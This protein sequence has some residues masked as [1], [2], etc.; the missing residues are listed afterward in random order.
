MFTDRLFRSTSPDADPARRLSA[1]SRLPPDSDELAELLAND[2]VP[3][4][5]IAAAEHCSNIDALAAAL[6]AERDHEVR[7]ALAARLGILLSDSDDSTQAVA[8]L[9]ASWC[10]DAIRTDVVRRTSHPERRRAAVMSIADEALLVELALTADIA[11]TRIAATERVHTPEGLRR[12]AEGT[13]D[14]DR[15]VTRLARNRLHA[16][17][18][19]EDRA[20]KADAILAELEAVASAPGPILTRV[21]ELNR[22]WEALDLAHDPERRARCDAVRQ[23]LQRRFEREH[24]QQRARSDL[25]RELA[26]WL[27]R[28]EPPAS[29]DELHTRR[30]ELAAL[31]ERAQQHESATTLGGLDEAEQRL[32]QWARDLEA[33]APAEAMVVEAE[34]LAAATS[35]DDAKLKPRW[36]ALDHSVR[37]PALARRFEAALAVVEQRRR[38]YVHAAQQ[39]ASLARQQVHTLLHAAE[40]ALAAGELQAARTAVDDIRGLKSQAGQL[41]KPTLQ[42][43][44]RVAQQLSDLERWKSFGGY[45]ACIR[46][47]ERAE[48]AASLK[49]DAPQLAREVQNLRKEWSA[50]EQQHNDVPDALRERFNRACE[51]AYAPAARYFAEQA[52]A[53]KQARRRREEFIAAAAAHATTLLNEPRDWRAIERWLRHTEREWRDG[54]VGSVEPKAWKALDGELNAALAPLREALKTERDAAKA[55]RMTLIEQARALTAKAMER[56]TPAQVKSLQSAWQT[57]A[58]QLTLGKRDEAALW[59]DFRAACNS[60]FEARES[61]RNEAQV[62]QR[63][64]RGVL[65]ALCKQV[66]QLAAAADMPEQEF[67]RAA[68]ELDNQWKQQAKASDPLARALEPRFRQANRAV[69]AALSGRVRSREAALWLTLA[70]K[71]RLCEELD[72]TV[73]Q[74]ATT[75]NEATVQARWTALPVLPTAWE[76]VMIARRDAALHA[77]TDAAAAATHAAHLER[78]AEARREILLELELLLGIESPPELQAQ[79]RAL[80][81]RRL[82]DRFRGAGADDPKRP[83]ERLVVWCA[84]TGVADAR[85]RQRCDRIFE[86]MQRVR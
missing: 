70:A 67:R 41:P 66:E 35:I 45:Q 63:E 43:L 26:D 56:D 39:E 11:D 12:I 16:I 7:A 74:G 81:V 57:E 14:T 24:A 80:Q 15:G 86:A 40:Q 68:R 4:V 8:C 73:G 60:I 33:L 27:A 69:E 2:P 61:K 62:R 34:Q 36:E 6:T 44:G 72:G 50:L 52:A 79:R 3:A 75:T 55:R 71:E 46:L 84:Q 48:A 42:R 78:G 64:A 76:K 5:R 85:D 53:R 37:I 31:R 29:S 49:V 83:G 30:T 38:A 77:L 13:R 47:C 28:A 23:T 65:E 9:A 32:A 21:I 17:I 19:D 59:E 51:K 10:S 25:E 54:D 18:G 58:K 20:G 22:C 82:R 1:V